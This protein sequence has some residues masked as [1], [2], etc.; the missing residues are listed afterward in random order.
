VLDQLS[1]MGLV[2]GLASNYDHRLRLVAAGFPALRALKHLLIS[3]EI[4]WRK[5]AKQF[6]QAMCASAGTVPEQLLY[7]GDHPV[8]D[9]QGAE[10]AGAQ[11]FLLD[12]AQTHPEFPNRLDRL[13]DVVEYLRNESAGAV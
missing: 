7:V 3:S 8:N 4:G 1:V 9:Y 2:L 6:F 11:A 13:Q 12:P 10:A 5:P